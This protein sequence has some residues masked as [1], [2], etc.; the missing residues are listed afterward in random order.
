MY[1]VIWIFVDFHN[2]NTVFQTHTWIIY[3]HEL[4]TLP[5]L[6]FFFFLKDAI[7]HF[8]IAKWLIQEKTISGLPWWLSGKESAWQCKRLVFDPW[9]RKITYANE[10]L[11]LCTTTTEAKRCKYWSPCTLQTMLWNVRSRHN[12]KQVHHY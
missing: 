5:L 11:N 3:I 6:S 8:A 2:K 10:W 7:K 12:E 4:F 1:Y 9:S